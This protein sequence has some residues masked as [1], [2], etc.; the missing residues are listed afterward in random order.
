V[1]RPRVYEAKDI[2]KRMRETFADRPV[3]W[4]ERLGHRWPGVLHGVGDSLA[5]AYASDKWQEPNRS[6]ERPIELYKHLAESRNRVLVRPGLLRDFYQPNRP[7][8]VRG[9]LVDLSQV[10]MPDSYAWLALFEEADLQLYTDGE[11]HSPRF[12]GP[13]EGVV[14]ITVRHGQL[15]GSMIRWSRVRRGAKDEPFLFVYTRRDG[16]LFVVV[17]DSLGVEADG[18]VG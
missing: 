16:V 18:I 12:G 11:D 8:P 6:G 4:E 7:W 17:G 15:G 1:G 9:P 3:E 13:E 2:A 14:K 5:V 10:P